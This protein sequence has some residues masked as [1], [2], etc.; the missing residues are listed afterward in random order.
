MRQN[1]F[2]DVHPV[3]SFWPLCKHTADTSEPAGNCCQNLSWMQMD[4]ERRK[5]NDELDGWPP[6]HPISY[7][8]FSVGI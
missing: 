1:L 6:P 8:T 4:D 2:F 3:I 5:R 7:S